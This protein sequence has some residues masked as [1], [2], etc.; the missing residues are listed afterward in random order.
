MQLVVLADVLFFFLFC[1]Q[2][3][4]DANFW[5]L[6][7]FAHCLLHECPCQ[8]ISFSSISN[9]IPSSSPQGSW[10]RNQNVR[11]VFLEASIMRT[12]PS[13]ANTLHHVRSILSVNTGGYVFIK[14]T[15]NEKNSCMDM[16]CIAGK[17][18]S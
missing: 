4:I 7:L 2:T 10:K 9:F 6:Y 8:S 16:V 14:S 12:N 15:R 13:N 18:I 5:I 11:D 3:S 1:Q 17:L